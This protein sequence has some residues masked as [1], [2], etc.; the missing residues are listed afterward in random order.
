MIASAASLT[1]LFKIPGGIHAGAIISPLVTQS[2][3]KKWHYIIQKKSLT[4][5]IFCLLCVKFLYKCIMYITVKLEF[6][7]DRKSANFDFKFPHFIMNF[8]WNPKDS[9][10]RY[11]LH[12]AWWNRTQLLQILF[13]LGKTQKYPNFNQ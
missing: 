13:A 6:N 7:I 4:K 10:N 12:I 8:S 3:D 9:H 11:E 2:S 5:I 1:F